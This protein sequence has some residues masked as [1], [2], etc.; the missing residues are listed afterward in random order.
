MSHAAQIDVSTVPQHRGRRFVSLERVSPAV[1]LQQKQWW[2][3]DAGRYN[4]VQ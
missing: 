3:V 4:K 2:D 1:R